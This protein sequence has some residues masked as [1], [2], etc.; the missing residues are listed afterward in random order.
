MW[1]IGSLRSQRRNRIAHHH[2]FFVILFIPQRAKERKRQLESDAVVYEDLKRQ[3]ASDSRLRTVCSVNYVDKD[4]FY[5]LHRSF[6]YR[7]SSLARESLTELILQLELTRHQKEIEHELKRRKS[8][9]EQV[10]F[11]PATSSD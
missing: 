10:D 9:A 6:G 5:T 7:R 2:N 1:S 8:E 3:H 4:D 11:S